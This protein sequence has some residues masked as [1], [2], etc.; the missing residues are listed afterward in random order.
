MKPSFLVLSLFIVFAAGI[1]IGM[2]IATD[3]H[4]SPISKFLVRWLAVPDEERHVEDVAFVA[5]QNVPRIE[6]ETE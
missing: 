3:G 2:N 5:R 6:D 4:R 1:T